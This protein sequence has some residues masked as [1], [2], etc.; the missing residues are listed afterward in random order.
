MAHKIAARIMVANP[1]LSDAEFIRA[2]FLTVLSVEPSES[3]QTAV[4]EALVQLTL[5]AKKS[6]RSDPENQARI[7]V[8][9]ALLNHNDFV[10]IR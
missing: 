9:Q 1:G 8:I 3:E 6:A 7:S 2:A 4:S 5:A 10:T